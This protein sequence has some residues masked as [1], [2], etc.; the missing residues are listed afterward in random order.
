[1][2]SIKKPQVVVD[3]RKCE[4]NI[5][6]MAAKAKKHELVFR[7]HFKTHQSR[8]IG[9]LYRSAGISR[10]TVS[11]VEMAYH[12]ASDGWKDITIAFPVNVREIEEIRR[13]NREIDL[14]VLVESAAAVRLL[15]EQMDVELN[16]FLEIDTGYGRTGVDCR[17]EEEL[18]A[19]F[20]HIASARMIRLK[21]LLAHNGH[22]YHAKSVTEV[23]NIHE[24][25][26]EKLARVK[27]HAQLFQSDIL[28]SIGDTPA[29]SLSNN[30][31]GVDEIRPGNFVYYD[32]QQERTGSCTMDQIALIVA[33]PVVSVRPQNQKIVLYGGAVHLSKQSL[34]DNG[35]T[36]HGYLVPLTESGW[37]DVVRETYVTSVSQEHGIVHCGDT[38]FLSTVEP[39]DLVG[40]LPVH[41]CLAANLGSEVF[42]V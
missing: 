42:F 29:C 17:N 27:E 36:V 40:I 11:S 25:S 23:I 34:N 30:F 18:D 2:N 12:F 9:A 5:R 6:N 28:V 21:G 15:N 16:V 13:L 37:G 39:G 41:A 3:R 24:S 38:G 32:L 4:T 35:R 20:H 31:S 10:I 14:S 22:T 26:L 7:P 1:M 33:C 8:E 19:M